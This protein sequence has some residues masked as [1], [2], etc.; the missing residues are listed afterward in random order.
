MN[1]LEVGPDRRGSARQVGI[2]ASG[3]AA[4]V[5][6]AV[7]G[8]GYLGGPCPLAWPGVGPGVSDEPGT[9]PAPQTVE[10]LQAFALRMEADALRLADELR[11]LRSPMPADTLARV[12]AL[13]RS[14]EQLAE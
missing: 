2:H 12:V 9:V 4:T 11:D 8:N 13:D 1:R 7:P 14:W 3:G 5:C 6:R 10:E